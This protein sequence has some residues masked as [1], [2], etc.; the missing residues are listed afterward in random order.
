MRLLLF[1][2]LAASG[3]KSYLMS[4]LTSGKKALNVYIQLDRWNGPVIM[5]KKLIGV[6]I[7]KMTILVPLLCL[8]ALFVICDNSL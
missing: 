3:L 2:I 1:C 5:I 8:S 4:L 7:K 6:S